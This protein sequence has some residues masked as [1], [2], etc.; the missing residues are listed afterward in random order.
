MNIA[1]H[2]RYPTG[3]QSSFEYKFRYFTNGQYAE[4]K[5]RILFGISH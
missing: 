3:R 2:E 4:F 1:K 5:V